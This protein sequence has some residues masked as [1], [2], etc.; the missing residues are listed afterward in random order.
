MVYSSGTTGASKGI[1]LTN[2]GINATIAQ[3]ETGFPEVSRQKKFLHIVPIWFSSGISISLLMPLCLG[4][5]CILEPLF[6]SLI[7][8]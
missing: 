7:H 2:D 4:A 8:I 3:Y 1:V 6:L 5:S